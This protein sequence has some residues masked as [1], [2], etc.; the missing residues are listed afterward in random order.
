[1]GLACKESVPKD[2]VDGFIEEFAR[3]KEQRA[4]VRAL[5][6]RFLASIKQGFVKR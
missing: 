2:S 1:M 5:K 4:N 6:Y 3:W